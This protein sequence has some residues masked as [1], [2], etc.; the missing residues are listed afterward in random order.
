MSARPLLFV[1]AALPMS[2]I[3]CGGG[4]GEE[5]II[6]EGE[7]YHYVMDHLSVPT[8]PTQANEMGLDLGSKTS[9]KLDKTIDNKL[10]EGLA[11]L[12]TISMFNL[13]E[14]IDTA[15]NKGEIV[16]L[17]DYQTKDFTNA[18]ASGMQ[19]YLGDTPNP[20]PCADAN[21]MTCGLHL[22]GT[23]MFGISADS[24]TE[25]KVAGKV[26]NGT[27]SGGPGDISIPLSIA[28]NP[29]VFN[30]ANARVKLTG[31]TPDGITEGILAGL[32]KEEDLP[33]LFPAVQAEVKPYV[34]ADCTLEGGPEAN[35]GCTDNSTGKLILDFL[36]TNP[37]D[38]DVSLVEISDNPT[39]KSI[40]SPDVCIE[41][42]CDKP[43]GISIGVRV[44]AKKATYTA[45]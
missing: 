9:N 11:S 25:A 33:A 34:M 18:A 36:D 15:I 27:F 24:P 23:G 22:K 19:V 5:E 30:L 13:Q 41:S 4:G 37:K 17:M 14:P 7:H 10:G 31:V 21:D 28:G 29:I 44:T 1:A 8:S 6:P 39:I 45:P 43:D 2:L 20:A 32:V 3:A 40:L 16:L 35:C 38:C 42:S 12:H 26:V